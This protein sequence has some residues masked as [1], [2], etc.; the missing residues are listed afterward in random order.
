MESEQ[1]RPI[2]VIGRGHSGTRV[3][4]QA[5]YASGVF[6]GRRLNRAGDSVPAMPMYKACRAIGRHV[7]W[8]GG[9]SWSFD[10]LQEG[11]IDP[12]FE[13]HV[14]EYLHDLLSSNEPLRGWKLPE[15]TLAYPWIVRMFP[16]VNYVHLVRDPRDCMLAPHPTDDLKQFSV[17]C[18]DTEDKLQR[19]VASWKYQYE[20]VN[21]TPR[22]ERFISLRFEDLV[23][24]HDSA[25]RRLEAFLGIPLAR[26]VV[27]E[28]RVGQWKHHEPSLLP[29]LRPLEGAM[30][31]CGYE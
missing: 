3:L 29:Y 12:E 1:S 8:N 25:M 17:D 23:L 13:G 2:A 11:E 27:D 15:T 5:L 14:R 16:E 28:T 4:S 24:D 20:I 10:R 18:P 7:R 22:P 6:M 19:R 21:A 30:R 9:L 26:V 31:E